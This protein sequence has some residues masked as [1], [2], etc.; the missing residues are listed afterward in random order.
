MRQGAVGETEL[1]YGAYQSANMTFG[2][3][4]VYSTP[5]AYFFTNGVVYVVLTIVLAIT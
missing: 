4:W 3:D 5:K 2:D 1:F